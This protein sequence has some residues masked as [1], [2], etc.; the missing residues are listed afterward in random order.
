[1]SSKTNNTSDAVI[2]PNNIISTVEICEILIS[3]SLICFEISNSLTSLLTIEVKVH[4]NIPHLNILRSEHVSST[5]LCN[6][7]HILGSFNPTMIKLTKIKYMSQFI[8]NSHKAYI[9][10]QISKSNLF[11]KLLINYTCYEI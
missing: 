11:L 4:L 9:K 3:L 8:L 2:D 7:Y 5:K 1:M 6:Y 10:Y